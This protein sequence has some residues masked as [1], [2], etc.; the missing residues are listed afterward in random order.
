M[1]FVDTLRHTLQDVDRLVVRLD[2]ELT[3]ELAATLRGARQTLENANQTLG[4]IDQTLTT[5]NRLLSS[6]AP[7]QLELRET[8]REVGKA[9]A[10]VRNL[11]DLLERQPEALLRGKKGE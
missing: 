11:A 9:A 2:K 10:T 5:T 1:L 3:P 4:K 7:L 6:D 8:L